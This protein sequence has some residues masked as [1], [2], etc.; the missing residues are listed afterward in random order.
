M[1]PVRSTTVALPSYK[2]LRQSNDSSQH[3]LL[4]GE[5]ERQLGVVGMEGKA[6]VV[7]RVQWLHRRLVAGSH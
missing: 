4:M 2:A 5:G 7:G 1:L 3:G 6:A